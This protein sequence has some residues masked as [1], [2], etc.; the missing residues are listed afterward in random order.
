M[1]SRLLRK[2]I[3]LIMALVSGALVISAGI[4][5]YAAYRESVASLG[6]FQ[7]EKALNAAVRIEQFVSG[8]AQ[9]I[10]WTNESQW[11]SRAVAPADQ[12]FEYL[13]LL[14]QAPAI[15]DLNVLNATGR[16]ILRVS[17]LGLD[18]LGSNRDF[19][20]DPKFVEAKA[21]GA[22][23][24][25]VYFRKDTEPY[26]TIAVAGTG[27]DAGVTVAEVN[28]KFVWDVVSRIHVGEAGLAYVLDASGHLVAHPDIS[29]V[30]RKLTLEGSA[31]LRAARAR[32]PQVEEAIVATNLRGDRV[33]TAH[34]E[35]APLSWFVFVEQPLGEAFAPIYA[36]LWRTIG[37]LLVALLVAV[38]AGV[39]FARHLVRPILQIREGAAQI[40]AGA[41]DHR[42]EVKTGDELEALASEFN[43]MAERLGESY[44]GL[45]QRVE[46]RTTE[47]KESLEHQTATGEILRV[48]AASQED[49]QP[50]LDAIAQSAV[51]LC[52][53]QYCAVFRLDG[54]VL[55][56]VAQHNVSPE[57]L[58]I[59]KRQSPTRAD[60]T[61]A[62]GRAILDAAVAQIPDVYGDPEYGY[63]VVARAVGFRSI[64]G[65]PLL[66]EGKPVGALAL[67]RAQAGL[68]PAKQVALLKAFADQAVIAIENV[69][70]F[71]ELRARTAALA[72]S[73]AELQALGEV[74]Q[75]VSSTL[76]LQTVLTTVLVRAAELS[77][78]DGGVIWEFHDATQTFHVMATHRMT[79]DHLEA[80]RAHPIRLGEGAIGKAGAT[81]SPVQVSDILVEGES[82]AW[83]VRQIITRLG[84]RSLLAIPFIR[85]QRLLGGLVV[86]RKWPGPFAAELVNLLQTFAAQSVLAI[87]NAR[88]FQEVQDQSRQLEIANQHK[89]QFLSAM[90]HELRTPLNAIIGFSE[91]LQAR[92]FGELNPKQAEYV[93]DIHASGHHLLSLINDILDL[94]K[95]EAGRTELDVSRF[96]VAASVEQALTLVRERAARAQLHLDVEVSPD[97]GSYAGDERKFRQILLNLLSN[98]IK[99]TPPGGQVRVSASRANGALQ[100]AV[101]DTGIGIAP[102]DQAHLF[103]AFHRVGDRKQEGTG[104]GLTLTRK[105]VELHRGNLTVTSAPNCGSTFTVSLPIA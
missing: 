67:A 85:E 65:V 90:S 87:Q 76:D 80:I 14:R 50:V 105:F 30:L 10:A 71:Q 57:S 74:G 27:R 16:E 21:K 73:V 99:F 64:T 66:R 3:Y 31:P 29:L 84:I 56:F 75:A 88:L 89:S 72:R 40:G 18:E 36:A 97:V 2:Y 28:L 20:A 83:Q 8:I 32:G 39:A 46:E 34:A 9:Q 52:D 37:L 6:R 24:S 19:S 104:L 4:E 35:I 7:R 23:F 91:A 103:E 92:F 43:R 86:W 5:L 60:R 55:H 96:E 68:L 54:E 70:L 25:P 41:L 69:R 49:V 51:A 12:R 15:T 101:S 11:G 38:A 81:G 79:P 17:R 44:A 98:A 61:S 33:L 13:R 78:C 100:V 95:I 93:D 22:Y 48:I 94:S 82:V 77:E 59:W 1:K 53:A 47:L 42:I 62:A 26:M 58:A 45:E 102:E 63:L